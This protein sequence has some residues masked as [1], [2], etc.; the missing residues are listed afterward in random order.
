MVWERVQKELC[1]QKVTVGKEGHFET[2]YIWK[3]LNRKNKYIKTQH[4]ETHV[5]WGEGQ[6][7]EQNVRTSSA[8]T[9]RSSLVSSRQIAV[10]E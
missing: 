8:V 7:E 10:T 2:E 1:E 5:T 6:H 9:E 4:I 3:N